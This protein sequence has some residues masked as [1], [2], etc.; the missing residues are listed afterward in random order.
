MAVSVTSA[1]SWAQVQA[2]KAALEA[3]KKEKELKDKLAKEAANSGTK[4]SGTGPT[5][6]NKE[7]RPDTKLEERP[8]TP[9]LKLLDEKE[10]ERPQR[11]STNLTE[12]PS[13][14]PDKKPIDRPGEDLFDEQND[15]KPTKTP[16]GTNPEANQ[17]SMESDSRKPTPKETIDN[18]TEYSENRNNGRPDDFEKPE[19]RR[20]DTTMARPIMPV[21]HDKKTLEKLKNQARELENSMSIQFYEMAVRMAINNLD[22]MISMAEPMLLQIHEQISRYLVVSQIFLAQRG[23]FVP[24]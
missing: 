18:A 16:L 24:C 19:P 13:E 11:P 21:D 3:E 8:K 2:A 15:T 7:L 20:T 14:K 1:L 4:P 12:K 17:P 6:E 22:S 10:T 9:D 23:F 5:D